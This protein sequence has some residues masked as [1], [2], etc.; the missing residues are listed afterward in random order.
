MPEQVLIYSR[1]PKSQMA[2]IARRYDLLDGHGK[3]PIETFTAEQLKPVRALITAGGQP[4]PGPVLD[5]LPSLKAI[6]CFGTGYDGV[7]FSE[8][9][10]RGIA[11]AN[12]PGANANAVAEI[13]MGLMLASMRRLIVAD[14][15]V[16]S[17][18]WAKGEPTVLTT[19]PPGIAGRK[20]GIYGLGEI[21]RKIAARCAAFDTEVGYHSRSRHDA[22]YAYFDNLDALAEWSDILFV[23]VRAGADTV[24]KVDAALLKKLGPLGTIVNI[25]RGSVIDQKALVAALQEKTIAGAGLDVYEKEPHAPDILT[26]LDNVVL[27]PHIGGQTAEGLVGM[28]DCVIANLDAFFAGRPLPYPVG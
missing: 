6:I 12:S 2:E 11:V 16:R 17:G 13:A 20:V 26:T 14:R 5:T 7:D 21:G 25:S 27:S 9:K 24:H 28:Q 19:M 15:Y 4:I 23:A 3:P 10:A 22:P 18:G 8:T 1:F